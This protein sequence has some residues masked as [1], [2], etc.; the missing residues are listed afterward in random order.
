LLI[1]SQL[2]T[3]ISLLEKVIIVAK[4]YYLY[5]KNKDKSTPDYSLKETRLKKKITKKLQFKR[6]IKCLVNS[7]T[8]AY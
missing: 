8:I 3:I 5:K 2:F 6:K 1:R 7:P 4:K